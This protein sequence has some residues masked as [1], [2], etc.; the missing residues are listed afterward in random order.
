MSLLEKTAVA[1]A[2]FAA[3]TA[4]ATIVARDSAAAERK[5][6]P[7]PAFTAKQLA[8]LPRGNWIT[9]GGSVNNQ[10][11][12]PLTFLTRDN[13]KAQKALGPSSRGR[14][15]TPQNSGQAQILHYEGV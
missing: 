14:G 11:S 4:L 1:A 8:E 9:N 5:V 12:P 15:A 10:R 3:I 7:A 6:A 13:V 2:T